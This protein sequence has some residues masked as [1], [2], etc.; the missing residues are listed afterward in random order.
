MAIT[1]SFDPITVD[2]IT[3]VLSIFGDGNDDAIITSRD[4][5]G[6][7]LVNGGTVPISGGTATVANTGQI[8]VSGQGG[9]DTITVDDRNGAPPAAILDGGDGNDLII[10]GSGADHIFGGN[11]NDVVQGGGGN[12]AVDLGTGDDVFVWN[13]GDGSD[14]VEG[15]DGVDSCCSTSQHPPAP[16]GS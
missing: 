11:D 7:I 1:T 16:A 8:S 2:P 9:N 15:G 3:G 12:D 6:N 13:A 4:A 14:T 10:G 5:S